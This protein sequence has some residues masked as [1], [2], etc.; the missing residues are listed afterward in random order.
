MGVVGQVAGAENT[1][2][3]AVPEGRTARET[4]LGVAG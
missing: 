4:A 1:T 2:F 3:R